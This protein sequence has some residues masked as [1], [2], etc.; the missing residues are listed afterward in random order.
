MRGVF[1]T[2]AHR[3]IPDARHPFRVGIFDLRPVTGVESDPAPIR[4]QNRNVAPMIGPVRAIFRPAGRDHRGYADV[5]VQA[6]CAVLHRAGALRRRH[7]RPSSR[8]TRR[9]SPAP[10]G[11]TFGRQAQ[12]LCG[13]KPGYSTCRMCHLCHF[14]RGLSG[15]ARAAHR[16]YHRLLSPESTCSRSVRLVRKCP[17][18]RKVRPKFSSGRVSIRRRA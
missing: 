10:H 1:V 13:A 9:F 18:A 7:A 16:R 3:G 6:A 12:R 4:F 14:S 15:S 8:S 17:S 2:A 11:V 5:P